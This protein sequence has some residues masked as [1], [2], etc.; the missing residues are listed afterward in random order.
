MGLFNKRGGDE[1]K[2]GRLKQIF[3]TA[4]PVLHLSPEQEQRIGEIFKEFREERQDL[5]SEGGDAAKENIR[6][7]RR[8]VK[9]KLMAVLND[10]QKKIF[11]DNITKWKEQAS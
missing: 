11:E 9:E 5:K 3:E 6:T 10:D 7:A 2:G 1:H 4:K 8:Q